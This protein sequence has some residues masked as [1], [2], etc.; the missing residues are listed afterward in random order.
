MLNKEKRAIDRKIMPEPRIIIN[1]KIAGLLENIS[2]KGACLILNENYSKG[3]VVNF[4]IDFGKLIYFRTIIIAKAKVMWTQ[5]QHYYDLTKIGMKFVKIDEIETKKINEFLDFWDK[6]ETEM[7]QIFTD[8]E[9][10]ISNP[11]IIL[12]EELQKIFTKLTFFRIIPLSNNVEDL[13]K[14]INVSK[15]LIDTLSKI[16]EVGT[17]ELKNLEETIQAFENAQN[18][19]NDEL[20]TKEDVIQAYEKLQNFMRKEM[21]EKENIL[22]AKEKV[23]ELAS[24]EKKEQDKTISVMEEIEEL[25]RNERIEKDEIIKAHE[26]VL[27]LYRQELID[28]EKLIKAFDELQNLH[29]QELREKDEILQMHNILEDLSRKELLEKAEEIKIRENLANLARQEILER[30]LVINAYNEFSNAVKERITN[31]DA[32]IKKINQLNEDTKNADE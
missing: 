5:N 26:R 13:I 29:R 6:D 10:V 1:G 9:K 19:F 22:N 28:K 4:T 24:D 31:K 18:L 32:L 27:D 25:M 21:I 12:K 20:K 11:Q 3:D 7:A 2:G 14:N 15:K 23:I 16:S 17:V 30:D 8:L